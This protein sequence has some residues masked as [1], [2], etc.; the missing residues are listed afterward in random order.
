MIIGERIKTLRK[1]KGW[2][3]GEL[4]KKVGADARQISRYENGHITPSADVLIKLAVT[5]DVSVDYILFENIPRRPLKTES[6]DQII[7]QRLQEL[8]HLSEE[9]KASIIHILDALVARNKIK[10]FAQELG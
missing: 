5:L 3:Q 9:D 10:S 6:E 1:E 8:Q 7:I 2:S 4:A